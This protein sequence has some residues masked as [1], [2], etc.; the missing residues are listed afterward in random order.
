M[1]RPISIQ[2]QN[3][4][5]RSRWMWIVGIAVG[6]A[7]LFIL[8]R[9]VIRPTASSDSF[10]FATVDRGPVE[11]AITAS[12][13]VIP[14]VELQI[15]SPIQAAIKKVERRNGDKVK[16]NDLILELDDEF[17][18]LEYDRTKDELELKRNNV[19]LLKLEYDKDLR[20]LELEDSIQGLQVSSLQAQLADAK[21]LMKV[22][23]ATQEEV[24]KATLELQIAALRKKKLEN[25]LRYK[26][27][28]IVN[29]RQNRELEVGIQEK[30][31]RELE[32]KLNETSVSAP[33]EGVITYVSEDLGK[34]VSEG[35]I[36]VRLADLSRYR[37]EG[38]SADLYAD[39]IS[40]GL[41]VRVRINREN[42]KG[43]IVSIL[44]SVENNNVRFNIAL[45]DPEHPALRPNMQVEV[46]IVT[47]QK[48][49]ALRVLNG[50]AFSGAR[51]QDIF[52]VEGDVAR[53]RRVR[54]GL[55]NIDFVELSGDIKA[56]EQ[57]I[58]S[59]MRDYDHL[60][61]IQLK[62]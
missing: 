4:N 48:D 62:P 38:T 47:N 21:R 60:E 31:L 61:V 52:V 22:G 30:N 23:G 54:I 1:D 44:P 18:R 15:T 50:P 51:E 7:A 32:R 35:E 56:G 37:I 45:E 20:D 55:N 5:T 58:L 8:F 39:R 14:A 42:L 3:R 57:I 13:R 24:E 11:Q 33:M 9:T 19:A 26:R 17:V 12:G 59:D 25:D 41:P 34:T 2:Q 46:F 36:L 28:S 16:P 43:M 6:I 40:T 29:N 53:K 10:R 49:N 27:L